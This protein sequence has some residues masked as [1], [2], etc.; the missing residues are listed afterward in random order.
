MNKIEEQE[1]SI[2]YRYVPTETVKQ[3]IIWMVLVVLF[4][5]IVVCNRIMLTSAEDNVCK[6]LGYENKVRDGG[7]GINACEDNYGNIVFVNFECEGYFNPV[8]SGNE[9][10]VGEVWGNEK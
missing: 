6:D 9:I 1:G 4:I 5:S 7:T 2:W 3:V 10:K 8:C